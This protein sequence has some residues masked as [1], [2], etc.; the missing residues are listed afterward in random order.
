[1]VSVAGRPLETPRA[2]PSAGQFFAVIITQLNIRTAKRPRHN[3]RTRKLRIAVIPGRNRG[4][5]IIRRLRNTHRPRPPAQPVRRAL[6][7]RPRSIRHRRIRERHDSNRRAPPGLHL[8]LPG[9][10]LE[11]G[12]RIPVVGTRLEAVIG[13]RPRQRQSRRRHLTRQNQ[14]NTQPATH[15]TPASAR[16]AY[17]SP[18]ALGPAGINLRR[19]RPRVFRQH[20]EVLLL[21]PL[22]HL[23]LFPRFPVYDPASHAD[24]RR[25]LVDELDSGQAGLVDLTCGQRGQLAPPQP[26]VSHGAGSP[27]IN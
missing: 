18:G 23:G 1:M 20:P 5:H 27:A 15:R 4:N 9:P 13:E 12:T 21:F 19:D 10:R 17:S 26:A 8:Q 25:S 14:P 3:H 22:W 11:N 24:R 6:R 2:T 16:N 7:T